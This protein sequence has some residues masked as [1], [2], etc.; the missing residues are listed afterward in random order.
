MTQW[1]PKHDLTTPQC[2]SWHQSCSPC[3]KKRPDIQR[4]GQKR[5]PLLFFD[6]IQG[7]W[8]ARINQ[9]PLLVTKEQAK[10]IRNY[11][12]KKMKEKEKGGGRR[13]E[14]VKESKI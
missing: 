11:R 5:K 8:K 6:Y 12:W 2:A 3:K 13:S 1:G 10:F 9:K 14:R 7:Y 4:Q